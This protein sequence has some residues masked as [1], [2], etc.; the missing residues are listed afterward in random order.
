MASVN[1]VIIIG[2]LGADP[3]TKQFANGGE[4]CN[5]RIATSES[6]KD[7]ATGEKKEATEWHSVVFTGS[8]AGIAAQY[9]RKGAM[10]YIE[11]ALRTRKWQDKQGQDRYTTE[12]RAD[13]M[14][15][16][17]GKPDGARPDASASPV[18]AP[19]AQAP[20]GGASGF[21]DAQDDIPF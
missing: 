21:D 12:I 11:G 18:Q 10:V 6:W 13:K 1:R 8:L 16:L 7:K 14:T 17:G 3:E 5:I 19:R 20:D 15:M 2:R 9:L 4:I